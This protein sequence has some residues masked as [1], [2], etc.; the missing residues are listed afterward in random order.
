MS[1]EPPPHSRELVKGMAGLAIEIED[2]ARLV[3][4]TPTEIRTLYG[5]EL[6]FGVAQANV[7]IQRALFVAAKSGEIDAI[8]LWIETRPGYY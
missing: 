2:I 3:H 7:E 1:H 8:K 6:A 4:A 5:E